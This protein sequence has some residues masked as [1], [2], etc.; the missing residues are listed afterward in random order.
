M[1]LG[2]GPW[3]TNAT[4]S[5]TANPPPG[6]VTNPTALRG[7]EVTLQTKASAAVMLKVFLVGPV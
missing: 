5:V 2:N 6:Q 4:P 3:Q 1:W 7:L